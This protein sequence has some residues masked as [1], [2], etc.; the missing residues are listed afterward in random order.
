MPVVAPPSSDADSDGVVDEADNCL[1]V[2]NPDQQDTDGD[3]AGDVCDLTPNG[4]GD[5]DGVDDQ[6]D[7]CP[8]VANPGQA[9]VDGDGTGDVCDTTPKGPTPRVSVSNASDTLERRAPTAAVFT[10]RLDRPTDRTVAVNFT[11]RNGTAVAGK[12]YRQRSGVLV[13]QPG[14][15]VKKVRVRVKAD[16]LPERTERFWLRLVG[17]ASGLVI[18]DGVGRARIIDDDRRR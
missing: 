3:G 6:V 17:P 7:N 5:G 9:D 1:A 14:E 4:D 18:S 15:Q 13:W 12:D 10:V 16:S 8:A 2:P 11:T